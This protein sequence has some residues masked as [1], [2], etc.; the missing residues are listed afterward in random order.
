MMVL[1][2]IQRAKCGVLRE[3]G[4]KLLHEDQSPRK[5]KVDEKSRR[6][7]EKVVTL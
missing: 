3:A 5:M 7:A 1:A 4:R 2:L 6:E